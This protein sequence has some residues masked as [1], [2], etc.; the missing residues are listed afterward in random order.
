MKEAKFKMIV[1]AC[2]K[3]Y[4]CIAIW[5]VCNKLIP[6][7]ADVMIHRVGQF[8]HKNGTCYGA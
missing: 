7:I 6:F 5:I 4:T 1:A 3:K 8:P 2:E